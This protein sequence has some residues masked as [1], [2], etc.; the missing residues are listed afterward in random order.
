M[1]KRLLIACAV[2]ALLGVTAWQALVLS[3]SRTKQLVGELV[4]R[5]ETADSVIALTFDD[6]PIPGYTDSVLAVLAEHDVPATFF[7]VGQ[8]VRLHDDVARRIVAEGHELGNHSLT[9]RRLLALSPSEM[10]RQIETT[11]SLIRAVGHVGEIYVRPPYGNRLLGLPLYLE[12]RDRPLVLWSLEPDTYHGT[13][14]GMVEYVRS[15]AH[16]GAVL[17]MHVEIPQRAE[18]RRALPEVIAVLRAQGYRF[19]LLS[20]LL[21]R[22]DR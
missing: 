16:P 15:Q 4:T 6:G 14:E 8:G 11:D 2:A 18:G 20:E 3:R 10:R 21:G 17:L 12:R 19:V 5:V 9:H 22:R 7:V 1:I 13:A